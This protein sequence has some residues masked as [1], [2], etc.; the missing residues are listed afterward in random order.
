MSL[1]D[2]MILTNIMCDETSSV[3]IGGNWIEQNACHIALRFNEDDEEDIEF[4][5]LMARENLEL[6]KEWIDFKLSQQPLA[7]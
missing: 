5:M 2:E 3:D 6:L 7:H 1:K 4:H